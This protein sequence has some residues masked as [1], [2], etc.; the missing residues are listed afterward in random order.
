MIAWI[1]RLSLMAAGQKGLSAKRHSSFRLCHSL[2]GLEGSSRSSFKWNM[3][4]TREVNWSE[5]MGERRRPLYQIKWKGNFLLLGKS[6]S[7]RV[8]NVQFLEVRVPRI[9]CCFLPP[10]AI[11]LVWQSCVRSKDKRSEEEEQRQ[12]KIWFT[13]NDRRDFLQNS[14]FTLD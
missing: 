10:F 4:E 1:H 5:R 7:F 12:Q 14:T 6:Q 11:N 9:F 3:F 13:A 8:E 2:C